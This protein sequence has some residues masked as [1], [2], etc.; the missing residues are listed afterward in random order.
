MTQKKER[1][2]FNFQDQL[3]VGDAGESDFI[4]IYEKLEP[5]KSKNNRK[6]DFTLNNGKTVELKTDSYSIEKTENFF[7][8]RNTILPDKKDIPGGPWRSKEHEVDYFVYYYINDK[9]FYWFDPI[10]LVK[11]LDKYI[12]ENK[13]KP[14]AIPN[15]DGKGKTFRSYGYKIPRKDMLEV[16]LKEHKVEVDYKIVEVKKPS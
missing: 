3:R 8:E 9:V 15:R 6:I 5:V 16:L 12:K 13:V 2:V 7:M 14:V 11:K 1:K 10:S 4:R